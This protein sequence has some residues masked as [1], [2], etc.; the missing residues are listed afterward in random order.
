MPSRLND[1]GW[2][3]VCQCP[4]SRT[5]NGVQLKRYKKQ[6]YWTEVGEAWCGLRRKEILDAYSVR[7]T[8]EETFRI[9]KQECGWNDCQLHDEASYQRYLYFSYQI[10]QDVTLGRITFSSTRIKRVLR[11]A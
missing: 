3:F 6:G 5:L 10:K 9:L 4:C 7:W 8:I 11:I 2:T 1:Y